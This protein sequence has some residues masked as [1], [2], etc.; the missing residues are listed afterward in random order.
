[1][2]PKEQKKIKI[3]TGP[4]QSGKT[5]KLFAYINQLESVDGILAPIV[6]DRRMLYHISSKVIKEL[7]VDQKDAN[8]IEVGK[9]IFL[10]DSFDWANEKLLSSFKEQPGWLIIDEIGKLELR[11]EGLHKSCEII[12][13][14]TYNIKTN[15]ILVVRDYLLDE[16]M[17]TYSLSNDQYEIMNL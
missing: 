6:D 17:K 11:K 3:F 14:E 9:Y 4:V 5:S 8:T 1:M 16:V 13:K 15:L 10:K 2:K 12:L 7:E